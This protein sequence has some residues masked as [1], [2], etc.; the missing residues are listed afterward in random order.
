M[1]KLFPNFL[2]DKRGAAIVEMAF[3]APIIGGMAAVS[4]GVWD[5]A[6]R[7]Q[8][9]R[10]ALDVA[11]EYYMHGGSNDGVAET[12]ATSAWRNAPDDAAVG[13]TRVCKCGDTVVSCTLNFCT[14]TDVQ[15]SVYI[16]LTAAGTSPEAM[17]TPAQT[18]ERTIRVR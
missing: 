5:V 9:M 11:A 7:Q 18:A 6:A 3:V 12:T 8:D 10:A 1:R 17:F 14:G 4:F 13:T 15:P 2:R 16:H